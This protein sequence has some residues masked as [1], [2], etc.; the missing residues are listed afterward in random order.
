MLKHGR[1]YKVIENLVE[2]GRQCLPCA[3]KFSM[4][5]KTEI[6]SK[7]TKVFLK[8]II[9]L[10]SFNSVFTMIPVHL[11]LLDALLLRTIRIIIFGVL[12]FRIT[13]LSLLL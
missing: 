2:H 7:E 9:F 4:T 13:I 12:I 8:Q 3:T 1:Q 6:L 11:H 5:L 10:K